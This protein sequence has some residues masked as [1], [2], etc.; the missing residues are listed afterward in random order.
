MNDFGPGIFDME[1][2]NAV[3]ASKDLGKGKTMAYEKIDASS[4]LEENKQKARAM[5]AKA[6]SMFKLLDGMTNFSL[7]HQGLGVIK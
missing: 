3:N 4:A 7:A 2:V 6:N 5:V 1:F